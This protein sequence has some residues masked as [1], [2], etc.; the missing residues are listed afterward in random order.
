MT[1]SETTWLTFGA[2]S[3][4]LLLQ[5]H[6]RPYTIL[7]DLSL[8]RQRPQMITFIGEQTKSRVLTKTRFG[9]RE[10]KGIS[11][12]VQLRVDYET[13][14]DPEPVFYA[15]C[16]LHNPSHPM[17]VITENYG[18]ITPRALP[19][20]RDFDSKFLAYQIYSKLLSPFSTVVCLFADD[21]GGLTGILD[22]LATWLTSLPEAPTDLPASTYPKVLI[23]K[24]TGEVPSALEWENGATRRFLL[25]LS[26]EVA[27]RQGETPRK[28]D[29]NV[30]LA[31]HFSGLHVLSLPVL[32][33][34]QRNW[35]PVR[36]RLLQESDDIQKLRI[37]HQFA[38]SI[39]HFKAFFH[40]AIRHFCSNEDSN[41][42]FIEASRFSNPVSESFLAHLTLFLKNVDRKQLLNFGVPIIASALVFDSYPPGMH[43]FHPLLV[44]RKFFYQTCLKIDPFKYPQLTRGIETAFCQYAV[45]VV[46]SSDEGSVHKNTLSRFNNE[47]KDIYSNTTCFCCMA[48][49]PENTMSC[50]HAICDECTISVGKELELHAWTFLIPHCIFCG[51]ANDR[52]F[53]LKPKTAG[54]RSIIAE[55]GGIKGIIPL[56]FLKELETAIGL[57]TSIHEHFDLAF[58]SSSGALVILGLFF[59]K[60]TVDKCLTHFQEFSQLVFQKRVNFG[61][62]LPGLKYLNRVVEGILSLAADSRYSSAGINKALQESFGMES[63]LFEADS[64]VKIGVIATTTDDCSTCIFANYNGHEPR[65]E[66]CGY[67]VIRPED[68]TKELFAWQAA[69]A[70]SAAPPYFR[71][72]GGYQDGGLGGHNNP[73]NLAIWE[74]DVIWNRSKKQP[75]ILVSLG[76]GFIQITKEEAE[77]NSRRISFFNSRCVPRLFASF[78]NLFVGESRW[79]ELCNTLSPQVRDRY[80]RLNVEFSESEPALDD[81]QVI[82]GLRQHV[83]WHVSANNEIKQCADNLLA[84]LFYIELDVLPVFDRALFVCQGRILCRLSP[85]SNGL[86]V[87][88]ARLKERRARFHLDF[89]RSVLAIDSDMVIDIDA[90]KPFSKSIIFRARSLADL[91]DIKIDGI[92]SRQRSISNC[93]YVIETLIK[94]QGLDCEFGRRGIK[95]N[96]DFRNEQFPKRIRR[97][98]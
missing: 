71:S 84:S 33:S 75:D 58:G 94:D 89:H 98:E 15:D 13:I 35:T 37:N 6:H 83:Q 7:G 95:R 85:S 17:T 67:R 28:K 22:I 80:H 27:G 10:Q 16:E 77:K 3:E 74:Q 72:F 90:G 2:G 69:R 97:L 49:R 4:G 64:G 91:L 9:F 18:D 26:K 51:K 59:N 8:D 24:S 34:S 52:K 41:F 42:S 47:W 60:W 65:S 48:R 45:N 19:F 5:E 29:L 68:K 81:T 38:F 73:I 87:L 62:S 66:N 55:G 20:P 54:V 46:S 92:V 44:F 56:S 11:G 96:N 82:P 86:Q 36:D 30:L 43:A 39:R 63:S 50:R 12:E 57:P 88:A 53:R 31:K 21:L 61:R 40:F 32:T 79:R 25:D 93:P 78:L 76:T 14:G 1:L 70:S 23:F